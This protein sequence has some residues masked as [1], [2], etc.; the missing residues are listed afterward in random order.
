MSVYRSLK[1]EKLTPRL[2]WEKANH[3]LVATPSGYLVFDDT[4]VDKS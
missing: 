2:V 3:T 4:V 1:R